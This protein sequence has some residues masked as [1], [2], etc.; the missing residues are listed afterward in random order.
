MIQNMK[1]TKTTCIYKNVCLSLG[2]GLKTPGSF[3]TLSGYYHFKTPSISFLYSVGSTYQ[4]HL[5]LEQ[6]VQLE[7]TTLVKNETYAIINVQAISNI[8]LKNYQLNLKNYERGIQQMR[9]GLKQS[10]KQYGFAAN[11]DQFNSGEKVLKNFGLFYKH[12]F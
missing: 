6:V 2:V 11:L 1:L 4:N 12:E 7:Y 10:K 3:A 9:L 8:N 5:T